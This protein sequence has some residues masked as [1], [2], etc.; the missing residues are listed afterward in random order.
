M[1]S[2][3]GTV[4]GLVRE[5]LEGRGA[6]SLSVDA[7]LAS[8][9]QDAA[10]RLGDSAASLAHAAG[11]HAAA[12]WAAHH[13]PLVGSQRANPGRIVQLA[14]E[15]F[16]AA[17]QPGMYRAVLGDASAAVH[18]PTSWPAAWVSGFVAGLVQA[19]G[20]T[21]HVRAAQPGTVLV[22][23]TASAA[24]RANPLGAVVNPQRLPFLTATLVPVVVASAIAA[25]DGPIAA[26]LAFLTLAGVALFHLGANALNEYYAR[27]GS[28]A[29]VPSALFGGASGLLPGARVARGQ[30]RALA[31]LFYGVGVAIG[32]YLAATRGLEVLWLGFA[33]ALVGLLY[34]TPPVRLAH[35][36]LGEL[37]VAVGFGPLIVL[38]TYFVQRQ[39]WSLEALLASLP[40]A[41]LIAA[42]LYINQFPDKEGDARVGKRTLIVRLP[43]RTAVIGYVALLGLTYVVILAGVSFAGVPALAPYA[44]P[45]WSL[46]GLLTLPLAAKAS[47]L[48]A[49]NYR[50]PYRLV[51]AN[52]STM[53]LHAATGLLFG[54]GYLISLIA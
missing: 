22:D 16:L 2:G 52:A 36:G 23:W 7:D 40:L 8:A 43:E 29:H 33:G 32:L 50:Y 10:A 14:V 3:P 37:A 49:R 51:S 1:V 54:A 47:V 35:R 19:A 44:F 48:L 42:V 18:L 28:H 9:L 17:Q 25:Q 20:A 11:E 31:L 53:L 15:E 34:S 41:F 26:G 5:Y 4:N 30:L 21:A 46:L 38:G 24:R 39:A 6:P 45:P 13:A 12:W 27:R